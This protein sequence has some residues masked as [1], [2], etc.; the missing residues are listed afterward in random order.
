MQC[1]LLN[2]HQVTPHFLDLSSSDHVTSFDE[3]GF[4][5]KTRRNDGCAFGE[6]RPNAVS[7]SMYNNGNDG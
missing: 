7:L 5:S 6:H 2:D 4:M 1:Q 3:R